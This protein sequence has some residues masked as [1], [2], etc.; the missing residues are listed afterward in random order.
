M[1]WGKFFGCEVS[2]S[3]CHIHT[4]TYTGTVHVYHKFFEFYSTTNLDKL[5][6]S[7][8]ATPFH[9]QNKQMLECLELTIATEERRGRT[10]FILCVFFLY[11][12]MVYN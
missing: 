10:L 7:I 6:Q 8:F 9:V 2:L 11:F 3:L 4:H 5:T 1:T 12:F